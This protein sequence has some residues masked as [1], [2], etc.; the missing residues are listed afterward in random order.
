MNIT[1]I[2][3]IT[4]QT[5]FEELLVRYGT[6][7]NVSFLLQSRGEDIRRYQEQHD[8]Y[9][10]A[11][12]M[13]ESELPKDVAHTIVSQK[14][15]Q[16]FHFRPQD[17]VIVTGPDGLFVN[18]AK[19]LT[20]Q[21]V[22]ALNPDPA[23]INGVAMRIAPHDTGRAIESVLND[24]A[25]FDSVTLAEAKTEEGDRLL[26]VNDFLVGRRDQV[27]ARYVISHDGQ[28][29][30]QSSSGV[31]VSTGMGAS[32]WMSSVRAAVRAG[33]RGRTMLPDEP[34]WDEERLTFAV[35][36]PFPSPSTDASIV[37]GSITPDEP[38][39]I[40]SDMPER[41]VV[42]SDGVPSDAL[43]LPAG[44]TLTIGIAST[45]VRLVRP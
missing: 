22:V 27:S 21:P 6:Y 33:C 36:E 24:T 39:R 2:V 23:N 13:A 42:F 34:S 19:Y 10:R 30:K 12:A 40:T 45:S 16:Q 15:I 44:L 17:L 7:G 43:Q 41:G 18:V 4:K 28:S 35:R 14:N 8:R 5:P 29:E 25:Q 9:V 20:G 31:L 32:G 3:L 26:A 37:Y 1:R 11:T 38:L